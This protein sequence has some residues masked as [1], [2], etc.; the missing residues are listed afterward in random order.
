MQS[1]VDSLNRTLNTTVTAGRLTLAEG[2]GASWVVTNR[3]SGQAALPLLLRPIGK[4]LF[5]RQDVLVQN[6]HIIVQTC[7]YRF[8]TSSY[9]RHDD[10]WVLRYEFSLSPLPNQPY[11]HLHVNAVHKHTAAPMDRL[12]LPSGHVTLEQFLAHLL[13]EH[14]VEPVPD[15]SVAEAM[16]SLGEGHLRF[17][18]AQ[19]PTLFP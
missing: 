10:A 1:Y 16:D 2:S 6:G 13:L 14:G 11:A 17:P 12:H 18:A 5:F 3:T 15:V 8:S 7:N 19:S 4:F 9:L